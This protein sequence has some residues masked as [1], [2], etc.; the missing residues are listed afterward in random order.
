MN[1]Y[2]FIDTWKAE[3]TVR[4]LCRVLVVPESSYYDWHHHGREIADPSLTG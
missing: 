2:R 1:L 4:D 3:F